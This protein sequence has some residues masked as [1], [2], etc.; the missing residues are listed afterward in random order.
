MDRLIVR[1]IEIVL[2]KKANLCDKYYDLKKYCE[3]HN[4]MYYYT[5]HD[6]LT[7]NEHCHFII[8]ADKT[9]DCCSISKKFNIPLNN[10]QKIKDLISAIRYQIHFDNPEKEQLSFDCICSNDNNLKDYFKAQKRSK[11][12]FFDY[13]SLIIDYCKALFNP[14]LYLRYF[15]KTYG[16][17]Y[18]SQLKT[19]VESFQQMNKDSSFPVDDLDTLRNI[20]STVGTVGF[21]SADWS[22]GFVSDVLEGVKAITQYIAWFFN[23]LYSLFDFILGILLWALNFP[24]WLLLK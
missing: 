13:E 18:F 22:G 20:V 12:A 3:E 16:L 2:Y 23:S 6:L 1:K 11:N 15:I 21:K 19:M 10:F 9:F 8:S 17:K 7:D 4:F 24:N 14:R 5:F